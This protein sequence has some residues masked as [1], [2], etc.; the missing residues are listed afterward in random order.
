M[1]AQARIPPSS[2]SSILI[3]GRLR[4]GRRLSS[5]IA[6]DK[7]KDHGS[8]LRPQT[9][10]RKLCRCVTEATSSADPCCCFSYSCFIRS[11]LVSYGVLVSLVLYIHAST[12][13]AQLASMSS[14][15][16][17]VKARATGA[18]SA[19]RLLLHSVSWNPSHKTHSLALL[20]ALR[21]K[22]RARACASPLEN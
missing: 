11:L 9:R 22:D 17:A 21:R 20:M 19:T 7:T 15:R 2:F 1:I 3:H 14:T 18:H 13:C 6:N 5:I 16:R 12:S 10:P 4:A 8:S